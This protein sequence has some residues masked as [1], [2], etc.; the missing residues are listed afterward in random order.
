[1]ISPNWST[2]FLA[3]ICA[4]AAL[5]SAR[6][7]DKPDSEVIIKMD[8]YVVEGERVMPPPESWRY[9][10]VPA[11]ELT[12]GSKVVV[13]PGYEILSNLSEKNTRL[14]VEEL[15]LR[16][17][18]G[19]L[20]WPM[21]VQAMPRQPMVV[22][23][24]RTKEASEPFSLPSALSW[25]GEPITAAAPTTRVYSSRTYDN[26][27]GVNP[28]F[29]EQSFNFNLDP[30]DPNT[31]PSGQTNPFDQ[32]VGSNTSGTEDPFKKGSQPSPLKAGFTIVYSSQGV[33]AAQINGNVPAVSASDV[34]AEEQLAAD[35][36]RRA[37][38]FTLESLSQRPPQWFFSGLGWL[39]ASTQVSPTRIT[40]A[41]VL[42]KL[43]QTRMPSLSVLLTKA[44]ALTDEEDMLAASFTHYGLYGDNGKHAEK[45][46]T[47]VQQQ[48]QGP[49]TEE[50]FKEI[51]G[52]TIKQMERDLATYSRTFAAYKFTEL[53]GRLPD[54][55]P[56]NV[57]EATQ[58]EVARLQADS[59]IAQ[60][61]PDLALGVLRIAYWRGEREPA[62]L[63]V[64]AGLE[65]KQGSLERA[66]K[67]T[68]ALMALATPPV[69]VL[70][71]EARLRFRDATVTKQP[72]E[73]LTVV[74]TR[75]IMDPLGRAVQ[76]GQVSEEN[77]EFFAQV[78]LRSAGQPH[79]SI[80]AF[81][82]RAAKRFPNNNTIHEASAF[83]HNKP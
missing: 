68:H 12:R 80:A 15:Q 59:L 81:L 6:A 5:V 56:V 25:Q 72:Q 17:L 75:S 33:V 64:L 76:A 13:A 31:G 63:A 43:D 8:P 38:V 73:K 77:C 22:V 18:A 37:A 10:S 79:E 1:M 83:A 54:M 69:R 49:V 57:R 58:S 44:T 28:A 16:Q 24:D 23:L 39:I 51:F 45:F 61:K 46:M 40:F 30:T 32:P 42:A 20:L 53:R 4:S 65:E 2:S 21:I 74:E 19:T 29:F 47:F 78:V 14:F 36:S 66:R 27:T 7:E 55:P 3:L 9:V 60:G 62:M 70:A 48:I 50:Q 71:V 82:D 41:D 34:P 52:L 26:T 35:L 11:G 67:I